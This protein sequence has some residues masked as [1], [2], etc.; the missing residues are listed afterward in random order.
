MGLQ[1]AAVVDHL[2]GLPQKE[3]LHQVKQADRLLQVV[4]LVEMV[5]Q[6]LLRR[7]AVPDFRP[8]AVAVADMV[9]VMLVA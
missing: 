7:P 2:Q 5:L 1:P 4:V 3:I 8:V 6:T 9:M